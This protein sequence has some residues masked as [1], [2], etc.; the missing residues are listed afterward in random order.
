M[1]IVWLKI[2]IFAKNKKGLLT[3]ELTLQTEIFMNLS[4]ITN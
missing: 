2:A 1:K 3:S 4:F